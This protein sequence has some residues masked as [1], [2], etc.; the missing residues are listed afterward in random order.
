MQTALSL[1]ITTI[2]LY[3]VLFITT[4]STGEVDR[5]RQ[6]SSSSRVNMFMSPR[7]SRYRQDRK[8]TVPSF[9]RRWRRRRNNQAWLLVATPAPPPP[10]HGGGG[11]GREWPPAATLDC[12]SSFST[13]DETMERYFSCLDGILMIGGT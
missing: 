11:G 3:F 6:C 7:S 1:K 10:P 5:W 2:I 8:S 4:T 12:S 9:R 13:D